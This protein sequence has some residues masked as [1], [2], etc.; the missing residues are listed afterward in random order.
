MAIACSPQPDLHRILRRLDFPQSAKEAL[1]CL[2]QLCLPLAHTRPPTSK[3]LDYIGEII[4]EFVF[5][6]IDHKGARRKRLNPLQE[7]QLLEVLLGYFA[8]GEDKVILNTV[9]MMLFTPPHTPSPSPSPS[10]SGF[11]RADVFTPGTATA[12]LSDRMRILAR[13]VSAAVASRNLAVLNC[14][15]VWMQQLGCLSQH[16]L[17]LS[18]VFIEDYFVLNT[19]QSNISSSTSYLEQLPQ[20]A[21][22]F[23]SCFLTAAAE[24]YGGIDGNRSAYIPPP[25]CLLNTIVNWVSSNPRLCLTPL[26]LNLQPLLP[27]GSI[28]M[29][30]VTPLAGLLKWCVEAPF[31]PSL[32]KTSPVKLEKTKDTK[33]TWNENSY[34]SQLHSSLL[35]SMQ[36]RSVLQNQQQLLQAEVISPRHLVALVRGLLD[37]CA[38]NNS[39]NEKIQL[40][41]DRLAQSVQV[42]QSSGCLY[43]NTHELMQALRTLPY[44]RLL[45]IV[46]RRYS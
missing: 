28:V 19:P 22:H 18:R 6:E 2:E 45:D 15:G 4:D 24:L 44:N 9:F 37:S 38:K 10:P 20:Q 27:K 1:A 17:N 40:S 8:A 21:P 36:E 46:V 11:A 41:L 39:S 29:T 13:L 34:Y 12:T 31:N 5:C 14:T 25:M 3:Q 26:T 42:A 33:S 16:S 35:E 32:K 43:G 23:T 30:S 7:L